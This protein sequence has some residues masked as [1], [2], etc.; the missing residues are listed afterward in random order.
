MKLTPTQREVLAAIGR[1]AREVY[2]DDRP[3]YTAYLRTAGS[4]ERQVSSTIKALSKL[5]LIQAGER[6]RFIRFFALTDEGREMLAEI[7]RES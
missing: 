5:G 7:Q 6:E 4:R 2:R 1:D 3:P